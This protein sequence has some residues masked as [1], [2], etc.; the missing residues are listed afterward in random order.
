M[1]MGFSF[2]FQFRFGEQLPNSSNEREFEDH[3]YDDQNQNSVREFEPVEHYPGHC[4]L[5]ILDLS[6]DKSGSLLH[7]L[8][9]DKSGSLLHRLSLDKYLEAAEKALLGGNPDR[10]RLTYSLIPRQSN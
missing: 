10:M 9:S 5:V 3:W 1:G 4:Q 8:S 2:A 7:R 6:G